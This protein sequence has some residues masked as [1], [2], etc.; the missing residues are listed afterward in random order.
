MNPDFI[1]RVKTFA[2]KA[3]REG[4]ENTSWVTP[5]ADYEAGFAATRVYGSV[6]INICVVTWPDPGL[7]EPPPR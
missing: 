7:R 6:N 4:K 1:D 2:V 3:A 5:N